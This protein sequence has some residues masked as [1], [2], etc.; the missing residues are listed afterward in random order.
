[1]TVSAPHYMRESFAEIALF[2]S[3]SFLLEFSIPLF[4]HPSPRFELLH[5]LKTPSV[6]ASEDTHFS[7][8][9]AGAQKPLMFHKMQTT[10]NSQK[11]ETP[12]TFWY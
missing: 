4:L 11:T 5:R 2:Q 12:R 7:S 1:M 3:R 9:A 8:A 6:A 10:W